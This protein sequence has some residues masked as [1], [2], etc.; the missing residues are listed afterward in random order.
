MALYNKTYVYSS[1]YSLWEKVVRSHLLLKNIKL[2]E[3][4]IKIFIYFCMYGITPETTE[5]LLKNEIITHKQVVYN[6]KT[7]LKEE[8][9]ISKVRSNQWE[10]EEPFKS[11][12]IDDEVNIIVKCRKQ[13]LQKSTD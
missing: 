4:H 10:I 7:K 12:Q 13:N 6:T 3:Q 9:L 1:E 11:M 8:G 5:F 2:Q